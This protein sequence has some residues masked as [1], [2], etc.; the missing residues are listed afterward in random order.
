M[1]HTKRTEI[2]I[3]TE[4]VMVIRKCKSSILAWC[5]TCAKQVPMIKVD[6]AANLARVS[7]RT[8]YRW[9]ETGKVH[10]AETPEG[11]LWICLNSLALEGHSEDGVK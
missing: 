2:T 7:S 1:R 9:V 10:F 5:P 6:E 4:R 8:I 3:E 11:M